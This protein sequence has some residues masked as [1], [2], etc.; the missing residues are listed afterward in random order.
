MHLLTNESV[1]KCFKAVCCDMIIDRIL[2]MS[3]VRL[4]VLDIV[5]Y[6]SQIR[7]FF[8]IH[9]GSWNQ[10]FQ[11]I[12]HTATI[13]FLTFHFLVVYNHN[14]FSI[15]VV[16]ENRQTAHTEIKELYHTGLFE[17]QL[18]AWIVWKQHEKSVPDKLRQKHFWLDSSVAEKDSI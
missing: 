10:T 11:C 15:C 1:F 12:L 7:I 4:S 14:T 17:K 5:P 3:R 18:A 6:S 8:I 2:L 9:H 13:K 16:C